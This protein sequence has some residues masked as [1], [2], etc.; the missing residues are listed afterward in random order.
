VTATEENPG[1]ITEL[2]KLDIRV[3]RILEVQKH[4]TLSKIF[5]QKIDVNDE[6]GP[7]TIC[8]GLQGYIEDSNLLGAHCIVLCNL[9]PRLSQSDF[10]LVIL[11]DTEFMDYHY[12]FL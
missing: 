12:T 3:G 2:S 8:S 1:Q 5:V 4:P 9:K 7:R 11:I 6:S 10:D